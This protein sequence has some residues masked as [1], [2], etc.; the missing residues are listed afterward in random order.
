LGNQTPLIPIF[1]GKHLDS[2]P[3]WYTD[4]GYVIIASAFTSSILPL[5]NLAFMAIK[6]MQ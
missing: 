1:A 5:T 3:E 2:S 6:V 4:V